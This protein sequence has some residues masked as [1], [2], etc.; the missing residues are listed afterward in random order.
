MNNKLY[1]SISEVAKMLDES[2]ATLRHWEQE[3]PSLRPKRSKGGTR[4]YSR[5]NIEKIRCIKT[6]LR[7][8]GLTI[9]GARQE[10]EENTFEINN[11]M[12]AIKKLRQ[13]REE[14]QTIKDA[15]DKTKRD[16]IRTE[17]SKSLDA[18]GML[19]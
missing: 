7:E 15:L 1:F 8:R 14:L 12:E 19:D 18:A 3:F 2:I 9:K 5:D 13:I 10:I 4:R 11:R 17:I 16:S 6:L